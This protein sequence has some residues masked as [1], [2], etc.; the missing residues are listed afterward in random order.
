MSDEPEGSLEERARA[1]ARRVLAQR[2]VAELARNQARQAQ[3][4]AE[5]IEAQ[6][7][8]ESA[9]PP[10]QAVSPP[11][12]PVRLPLKSLSL[13]TFQLGV[14][15]A[16]SVHI[17]QALDTLT[18]SEDRR[19]GAVAAGLLDG[20]MRGRSLSDAMIAQPRCFDRVYVKMVRTG[21]LGGCL[22]EVLQD[23]GRSLDREERTRSRVGQAL[24]YPAF[25][26][27]VSM[28]M[29]A[30]LVY[31]MVPR[32]LP[33]FAQT[34]ASLPWVTR[35]LLVVAQ[36]PGVAFGAPLAALL[37][38]LALSLQNLDAMA[39]L[40]ERLKFQTPVLG[41]VNR[42][43]VLARFCS[44]LSL[45]VQRGVSLGAALKT[46]SEGTGYSRLDQAVKRVQERLEQGVDFSRALE[47]EEVFPDLICTMVGAGEHSGQV[48]PFLRRCADLLEEQVDLSLAGLLQIVEPLV[49]AG[50]GLIVGTIVV[51]V[52]LPLYQL[53]MVKV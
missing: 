51:A 28:L 24:A 7:K 21:E 52:F 22:A 27:V 16:A 3:L 5:R 46:L 42:D 48:A 32:F 9:P 4:E 14:M 43:R 13:F 8:A 50:M 45:L 1:E 15:M 53:A 37:G 33:A 38:L 10:P 29:V 34:G 12:Q 18:R 17:V 31:Y 25:L 36:N 35:A 49:L 40:V 20:L 2:H 39:G 41:A 30:F 44:N 19:T 11:A 26:M 23:L 6:L 47:E